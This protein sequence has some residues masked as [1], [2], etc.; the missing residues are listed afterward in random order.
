MENDYIRIDIDEIMSIV[1]SN[2][3]ATSKI[4]TLDEV[5]ANLLAEFVNNEK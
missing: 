3:L 4:Y 5:D 2:Y 1:S